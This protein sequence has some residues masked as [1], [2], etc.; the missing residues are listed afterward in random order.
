[1]HKPKQIV[2]KKKKALAMLQDNLKI[3]MHKDKNYSG[4]HKVHYMNVL[5]ALLKRIL[6]EKKQDYKLK[7]EVESRLAKMWASKHRDL[8]TQK[9]QKIKMTAAELAAVR[10]IETW[11]NKKRNL[12]ITKP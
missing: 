9:K 4:G 11:Y 2:I 8:K 6:N 1:M 12:Q 3:K 7:G 10:I 5:R